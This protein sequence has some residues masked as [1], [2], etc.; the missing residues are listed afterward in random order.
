[1]SVIE[2]AAGTANVTGETVPGLSTA[3]RPSD[4][5]AARRLSTGH[6]C[7]TKSA[8]TATAAAPRDTRPE[9]SSPQITMYPCAASIS[10]G[11]PRIRR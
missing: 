11:P 8:I 7:F 1:M 9:V 6:G 10:R 4:C 3:P 5:C 2:T